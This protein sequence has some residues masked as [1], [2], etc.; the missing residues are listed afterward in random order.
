MEPAILSPSLFVT[1]AGGGA[2]I[3]I[4]P[5]NRSHTKTVSNKGNVA[6]HPPTHHRTDI[7][8]RL[9]SV[10]ASADPFPNNLN[11][12]VVGCWFQVWNE[13]P[14]VARWQTVSANEDVD[15]AFFDSSMT[16]RIVMQLIDLL[17]RSL[18]IPND[19]D[20]LLV[21]MRR[22]FIRSLCMEK[23][24]L[25]RNHMK[26]LMYAR[27]FQINEM[28]GVVPDAAIQ[29]AHAALYNVVQDRKTANNPGLVFVL[30]TLLGRAVFTYL[31]RLV[32]LHNVSE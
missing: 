11:S 9:D 18:G 15:N 8:N 7:K 1:M 19:N 32:E 12:V 5:L 2:A 29:F 20:R 28:Q 22:G 23:E 30:W 17:R 3:P 27:M 13:T 21:V 26:V 14:N 10:S 25:L 16:M 6:K 4:Y 31:F 24:P